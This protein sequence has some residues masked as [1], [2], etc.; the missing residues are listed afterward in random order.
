M[1]AIRIIN[2]NVL[3]NNA[4]KAVKKE[5]GVSDETPAAQMDSFKSKS[6]AVS[7]LVYFWINKVRR[8]G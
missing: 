8:V 6:K 2:E 1:M 4:L 5:L 7:K 3:I